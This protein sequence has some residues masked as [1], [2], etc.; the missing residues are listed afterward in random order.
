[1]ELCQCEGVGVLG[2]IVTEAIE[3]GIEAFHRITVQRVDA[4]EAHG[5]IGKPLLAELLQSHDLKAMLSASEIEHLYIHLGRA[6]EVNTEWEQ[7][8]AVYTSLLAYARDAC[9]PVMESTALNRLAILAA[10]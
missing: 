8:R 9:E 4:F 3:P 6:Y 2:P 7:A 5:D 10:Q 1:M